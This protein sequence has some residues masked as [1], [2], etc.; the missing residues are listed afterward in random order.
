[1]EIAKAN[2]VGLCA[3]ESGC[4]Y[5]RM[6]NPFSYLAGAGYNCKY[7]HGIRREDL[8]AADI[9]IAQRQ[10]DPVLIAKLRQL[11]DSGKTIIVELDDLFHVLDKTNIASHYIKPEHLAALQNLLSFAH[12]MTVTTPELKSYYAKW[13]ANIETVP[14]FIDF[15]LREW[16]PPIFETTHPFTVGWSGS[17]SHFTELSI[18]GEWV[19]AILK[20]FPEVRYVHYADP[21]FL[22]LLCRD[23]GIDRARCDVIETRKFTEYNKPLI[24]FCDVGLVPLKNTVFNRCKSDLKF[25]EYGAAGVLPV[26]S[27]MPAYVRLTQG[28]GYGYTARDV[29]DVLALVSL[30]I[31][32]NDRLK[33]DKQVLYTNVRTN[34]DQGTRANA[35][36]LPMAWHRIM[37]GRCEPAD[38]SHKVGRNEPCP[39]GSGRKVKKCHPV[40][41]G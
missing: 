38:G 40:W 7:Y 13:N 8:E 21:K 27:E 10:L 2:I 36:Q 25:L 33:H 3:D 34:Y 6:M 17:A 39:C 19:N 11:K 28:G 37:T 41:M 15:H 22:D 9:I 16:V 12:G 5:Y 18:L 26:G 20:A 29:N 30:Y 31:Q 35:L 23:C 14:N 1:M 32:D 24:N 4:G